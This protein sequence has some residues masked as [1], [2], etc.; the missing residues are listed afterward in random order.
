MFASYPYWK[1]NLIREYQIIFENP[2]RKP[3]SARDLHSFVQTWIISVSS[4]SL[5]LE[6]LTRFDT[7]HLFNTSSLKSAN[8]FSVGLN[9]PLRL[10]VASA[11]ARRLIADSFRVK[12]IYSPLPPSIT[13][14]VLRQFGAVV[15]G[16]IGC[17]ANEASRK[18]PIDQTRSVIPRT[19]AGVLRK[20]S[21]TRQ[22][23]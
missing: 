22:K 1:T 7:G 10:Y 20:L 2:A 23:L 14:K 16:V 11:M 4:S 15:T 21:C 18:S 6:L 5:V 13:R 17:V 8:R 3:T 9:P 19:I 12:G